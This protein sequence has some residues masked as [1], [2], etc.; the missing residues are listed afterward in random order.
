MTESSALLAPLMGYIMDNY[1][2][3]SCFTWA[4]IAVIVVTLMLAP[5]LKEGRN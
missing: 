5:L 3:T 4:S 1:G 2:F